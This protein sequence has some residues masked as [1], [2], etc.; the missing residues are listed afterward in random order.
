MDYSGMTVNERIVVGGFDNEF[1]KARKNK[2][3][4]TMI[5][6]LKDVKLDDRSIKDIVDKLG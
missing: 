6:I 4:E 1:Q 3:R 5:G 2:D